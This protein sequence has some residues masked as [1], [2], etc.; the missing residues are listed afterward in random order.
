MWIYL[1]E[2]ALDSRT[3]QRAL[4]QTARC[5]QMEI[6]NLYRLCFSRMTGNADARIIDLSPPLFPLTKFPR[7]HLRCLLSYLKANLDFALLP[8]GNTI[9]PEVWMIKQGIL[10]SNVMHVLKIR[11]SEVLRV[12]V[13][14]TD[15]TLRI[16]RTNVVSSALTLPTVLDFQLSTDSPQL[17]Q[18]WRCTAE[19]EQETGNQ[20]HA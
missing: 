2:T 15:E 12:S 8:L 1:I 3:R 16:C 19:D 7:T 18:N 9:N 4:N 20:W 11:N 13:L 6:K 14:K 5:N 10:L 17:T